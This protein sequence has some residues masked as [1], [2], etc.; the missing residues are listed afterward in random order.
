MNSSTEGRGNLGGAPKPPFCSSRGDWIACTACW[1]RAGVSGSLSA[2][3]SLSP[4]SCSTSLA[5]RETSSRFFCQRTATSLR[6][7]PK[8]G[9]PSR[10]SAG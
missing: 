7:L 3:S 9:S 6:T 8:A 4:L 1:S 2:T 10:A 5:F